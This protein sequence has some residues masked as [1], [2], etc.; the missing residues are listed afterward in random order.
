MVKL[1][2]LDQKTN[3]VFLTRCAIKLLMGRHAD[4]V[5]MSGKQCRLELM[6]CA[7]QKKLL[8]YFNI[9]SLFLVTEMCHVL[10]QQL[11]EEKCIKILGGTVFCFQNSTF[12]WVKMGN[13]YVKSLLMPFF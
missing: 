11:V 6:L 9:R 7:L 3:L 1:V 10:I 2:Q 5:L 4:T 8:L 12:F 13:V